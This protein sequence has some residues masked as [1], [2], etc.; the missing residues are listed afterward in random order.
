MTPFEQGYNAALQKLALSGS[1]KGA[2][3][4]P[5]LPGMKAPAIPGVSKP[6]SAT[7]IKPPKMFDPGKDLGGKMRDNAQAGVSTDL[8]LNSSRAAA[9]FDGNKDMGSGR[10]ATTLPT[11]SAR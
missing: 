11:G 5:S 1:A 6:P 4:L 2:L 10:S 7:P 9:K 3:G 8:S